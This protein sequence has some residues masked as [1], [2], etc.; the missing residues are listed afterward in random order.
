MSSCPSKAHAETLRIFE[1][2]NDAILQEKMKQ[3]VEK[4]ES[5]MAETNAETIL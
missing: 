3:V 4:T 1:D 5:Q 2:H